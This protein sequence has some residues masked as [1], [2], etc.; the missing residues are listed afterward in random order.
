MFCANTGPVL[1]AAYGGMCSNVSRRSCLHSE[2]R[3]T[4]LGRLL[5]DMS[6][7]VTGSSDHATRCSRLGRLETCNSLSPVDDPHANCSTRTCIK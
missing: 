6:T 7:K 3:P 1:P 4:G 2:Q 5:R